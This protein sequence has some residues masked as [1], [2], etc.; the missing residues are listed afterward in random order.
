MLKQKLI[1]IGGGG[2]GKACIDVIE[3]TEG[4]EIVGIL[5]VAD[6]VGQ[7][8]LN[9]S[10][11]GTNDLISHLAKR[12]DIAFII[13]VG[14]IKSAG[15]RK[16]IFQKLLDNKA[17]IATIISKN[18]TVSKY[19]KIGEGTV[20]FHGAKINADAIIGDNCIINTAA[21]IEHDAQIGQHSHISTAVVV[22]GTCQIG[23]EVFIGSN[24]VLAN[25]INIA[26]NIV[27]GAGSVVYKS[28]IEAGI[29]AGNPLIKIR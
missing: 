16:A 11:I 21:I 17:K 10:I 20:I 22:N 18:A 13:T 29:Y 19:A 8:I 24:T 4:Y 3:N 14:Q 25:N 9:Y 27:I 15:I 1:L 6:K 28:L 12:S 7:S 2:H 5:D 23:Q 26:N